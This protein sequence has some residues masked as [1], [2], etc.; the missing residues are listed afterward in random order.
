MTVCMNELMNDWM[1]THNNEFNEWMDGIE[2]ECMH[3][4]M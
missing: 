3:Y 4:I 2:Y 1:N